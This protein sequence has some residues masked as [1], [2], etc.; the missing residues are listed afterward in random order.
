MGNFSG[1]DDSGEL[2]R[3][4]EQEGG[5]HHDYHHHG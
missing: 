5:H 4:G 2:M 1:K 3:D